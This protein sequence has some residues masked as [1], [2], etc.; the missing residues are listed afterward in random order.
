VGGASPD[1]ALQLAKDSPGVGYGLD[2]KDCGIFGGENPYV[3][4]GLPALPTVVE[5]HAPLSVSDA[6]GLPVTVKVQVNP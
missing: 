3:P 1:K 5:I 6:S 4:S 2:G